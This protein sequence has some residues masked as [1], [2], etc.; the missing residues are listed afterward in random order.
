MR[1]TSK[2]KHFKPICAMKQTWQQNQE[3]EKQS[4]FPQFCEVGGL[5]IANK[6]K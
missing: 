4:C 1:T 6:R 3:G 5:A 2:K